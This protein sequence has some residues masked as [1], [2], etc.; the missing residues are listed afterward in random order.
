MLQVKIQNTGNLFHLYTYFFIFKRGE[1]EE[2]QHNCY[3]SQ[4]VQAGSSYNFVRSWIYMK[5]L[6]YHYI[7]NYFLE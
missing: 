2:P 7:F 6:C 3:K 1:N 5:G 4:K